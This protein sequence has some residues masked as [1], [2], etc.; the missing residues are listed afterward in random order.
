M[1]KLVLQFTYSLLVR[2]FLRLIIGVQFDDSKF[3]LKEEQ[4][5]IVAN[6]NSHLDT[7]AIMASVPRKM[8]H[9][10]QPVAAQD[11]F[12][13]TKWRQTVGRFFINFLLIPRKRGQSDLQDDPISQMIAALD[14][15][16]SLIIFPEGTRGEP[17]KEQPLKPGIGKVLSLR[18]D[19]KYVPV[20]MYGMGKAMPK[21]D[22]LILP[23]NA[24]LLYGQPTTINKPKISDILQQIEADLS[25][26]KAKMANHSN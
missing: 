4:F 12:G 6:H 22:G 18:P 16:N 19:I 24:R 13:K 9:K 25:D 20:F 8:V 5:I 14:T 15:G 3:L 17:E 26:L 11:Y 10:I 1:Q 2:W 7:M 23:T 21:G